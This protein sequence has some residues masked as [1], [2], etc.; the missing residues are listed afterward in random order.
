MSELR[1]MCACVYCSNSQ[2][3]ALSSCPAQKSALQTTS[4]RPPVKTTKNQ[5][6][7]VS[8]LIILLICRVDIVA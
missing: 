5:K 6:E 4:I 8:W 3:P 2:F 1:K 7:E